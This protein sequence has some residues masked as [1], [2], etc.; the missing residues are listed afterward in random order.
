MLKNHHLCTVRQMKPIYSDDPGRLL[1]CFEH[2]VPDSSGSFRLQVEMQSEVEEKQNEAKSWA[3]A[4][5]PQ[6]ES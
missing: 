1:G 5:P 3:V 4:T 6:V 2:F